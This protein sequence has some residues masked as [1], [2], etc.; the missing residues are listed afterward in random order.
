MKKATIWSV[1][2]CDVLFLRQSR[3]NG[4]R[5]VHDALNWWKHLHSWSINMTKAILNVEIVGDNLEYWKVC[6]N[7]NFMRNLLSAELPGKNFNYHFSV[8]ILHKSHKAELFYVSCLLRSI[9]QSPKKMFKTLRNSAKNS[10]FPCMFKAFN[11][12]R[13]VERR[14]NSNLVKEPGY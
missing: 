4:G 13:K 14:E 7:T 8:P 5:F 6:F 3:K 2:L 9:L 12:C 1:N 11:F 10:R